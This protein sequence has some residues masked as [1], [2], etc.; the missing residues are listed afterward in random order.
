MQTLDQCKSNILG[1][2]GL[3]I[4]LMDSTSGSKWQ[5]LQQSERANS[6]VASYMSGIKDSVTNLVCTVYEIIYGDNF[7]GIYLSSNSSSCIHETCPAF[8]YANHIS[9]KNK[10]HL[11]RVYRKFILGVYCDAFIC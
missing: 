4:T 5:V 11:D 6:R 2:L 9:I 3:P 8:L 10:L 7:T 1:P